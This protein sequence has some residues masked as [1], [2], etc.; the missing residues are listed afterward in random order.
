MV[1]L[2]TKMAIAASVVSGED[3][4]GRSE[5]Q[6]LSEFC[7]AVLTLMRKYCVVYM[8][9]CAVKLLVLPAYRSTDFE[10]H[11]NWM[12][13]T[14]RLPIGDWYYDAT[15]PWTLDYPPMFAYFEWICAQFAN[16]WAPNALLVSAVPLCA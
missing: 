9:A 10:V 3:P 5:L 8:A 4:A 1:F 6:R 7:L 11:R 15:S 13:I 16:M 12:A 14:Y 2:T